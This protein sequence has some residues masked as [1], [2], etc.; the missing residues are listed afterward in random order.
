ME[1]FLEHPE[2]IK[3]MGAKSRQIAEECLD[4][5]IVSRSI[6][7]NIKNLMDKQKND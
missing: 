5:E 1:Y 7:S 4:A 3:N 2:E 6:L